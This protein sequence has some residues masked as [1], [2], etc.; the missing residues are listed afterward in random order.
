MN[1]ILAS[2]IPILIGAKNKPKS[3]ISIVVLSSNIPTEAPIDISPANQ[4]FDANGWKVFDFQRQ[5]WLAYLSGRSGLVNA[6]TGVAKPILL[7]SLSCWMPYKPVIIKLQLIWITPIRALAKEICLASERGHQPAGSQLAGRS[8]IGRYYHNPTQKQW[9]NP[10]QILITTPESIHVML[11][12]PRATTV[13]SKASKRWWWMNGTNWWAA[14]EVFKPNCFWPVLNFFPA[15][16]VWGISATIGNMQEA[17]EG[18]P[19]L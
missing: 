1:C 7:S 4:W 16:R 10:P 19:R 15:L 11:A 2:L 17:I 18:T 6:P 13:F 3:Q 9:E 8:K 12:K 14:K 5:T